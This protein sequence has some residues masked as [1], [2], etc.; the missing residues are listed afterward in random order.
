MICDYQNV[1]FR[2]DSVAKVLNDQLRR[3]K[4]VSLELIGGICEISGMNCQ[5]AEVDTQYVTSIESPA[6][7]MVKDKPFIFYGVNKKM[8]I[9][10]SA[11]SGFQEVPYQTFY[12]M[13]GDR[14]KFLLPRRTAAT[15]TTRFGWSWFTPLLSKYK[16]ALLLVFIASLLSQLFGLAIPLLL[17]QIIDK[18][19][20]QGNLSSL[21][22]L[23]AAMVL[24]ALFQGIL[25]VLRSYIFVDTTD[26]MDLTLGSAVIDRLLS[27][28]LSY[29]E[30]RPVGELSQRL[31]ELNNIRSFLTGTALLSTLNIIF[32]SLYLVVMFIYSPF[33]SVVALSSLPLY[34]LL[35]LFVSPIYRSLIRKR[36]V[37]SAKTQSHL[38]EVISGI[39]TVKAQHF[40]LTARWKWQDRYRRFVTEGF[41]SVVLGG[42]AGEI[43][44]FLNQLS[45]LL[46]L[47][48]GMSLVLK[49]EFS[50][51]QLIAF[52]IISG[53]VTGPLLQLAGLYQ[54]F[55]GVQLSM[56]RLSDIVD[57]SPELQSTIETSQITL[58]PIV[59][60]V[61]FQNV[62]QIRQVRS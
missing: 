56:E 5:L 55:Q 29:F 12:E 36:A 35:D 37:A 59:G 42:A 43:G 62:L 18:V 52:R 32:A 10:V 40:E 1:P 48:V 20:S 60:H 38:I 23:G 26:R 50:L 33:L 45:G 21:N 24:M 39:Q 22:I 47:W 46:V 61:E 58:P 3:D 19:L 57:Q 49:G 41:K 13:V 28:P 11:S 25:N 7:L 17:Q 30:K 53:N 14:L 4:D 31:G 51:G 15:P 2:K 9:L 44:S 27:L 54:G 16:V 6:V 8:L 34:I